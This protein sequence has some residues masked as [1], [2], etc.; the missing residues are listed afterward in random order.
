MKSINPSEVL[1]IKL[2]SG[3]EYE[4]ECITNG[5]LQIGFREVPHELYIKCVKNGNWDEV[6][7]AYRESGTSA[8]TATR[9]MHQIQRFY[10]ADENILWIT[11]WKGALYWCFA[12]PGVEVKD[13]HCKSRETISGWSCEDINGNQLMMSKLSGKV[14]AMQG[15]RGTICTVKEAKYLVE[16][17]NGIQPAR[18]TETESV[19]LQLQE[20]VE[21]IIRTLSWRDFEILIDLIFRQAGWQRV[22]ELGGKTKTLDIELISPITNE[23]YG[24]QVKSK[25]R[26]SLFEEYKTELMNDIQGGFTR[27]YFAVHSPDED[28][29]LASKDEDDNVKLLLPAD[30]SRLAVQYGLT[31]WV[32]DKAK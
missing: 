26:L 23:R 1:Y 24:V 15:F 11:F 32:I 18:V 28:L 6:Q 12:K 8:G 19:L 4:K 25:A 3:G 10:E 31:Q 29:M 20:K 14:L 22:N 30:I 13:N 2:G 27:F 7:K 5:T 17:I 21:D 9:Y 16:K